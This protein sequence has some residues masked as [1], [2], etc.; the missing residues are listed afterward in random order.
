MVFHLTTHFQRLHQLG[1]TKFVGPLGCMPF[2]RA[3]NLIPTG[4]CSDQVNQILCG[5]N[6]KLRL[7]RRR[8]HN[9]TFVYANSL[10]PIHETSFQLWSIWVGER[11]QALLWRLFPPFYLLQG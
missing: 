7:S 5:Y 6:M 2:A 4:K 8:Y 11:V 3:F 10:R 1:A 9:T